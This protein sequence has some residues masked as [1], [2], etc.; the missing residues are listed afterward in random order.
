MTARAAIFALVVCASAAA[1]AD[2]T[3]EADEA[4]ETAQAA[5]TADTDDLVESTGDSTGG[6][7]GVAWMHYELSAVHGV[8]APADA[9]APQTLALGGARV[10]GVLGKGRVGYHLG[11]DFAFGS[12]VGRAGFA[13][14][15]ALFPLGIGLRLGRTGVL[16][17]GVGGQASGA[18]GAIDDALAVPVEALLEAGG[19]LRLLVRARAAWLVGADGRQRGAPSA[20]F[21]DEI[22]GM[23]AL[24]VGHAYKDFGL[25]SGNGYFVGAAFRE[26][27]GTRF[28][29]LVIGYSVDLATPRPQ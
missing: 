29:G 8:Q 19:G 6:V 28:A 27:A 12:T 23:L 2:D 15:V 1:R 18:V 10:H 16:A 21:A 22:E 25:P 9:M 4:D 13:Y 14:D 26:L 3:D 24:R 7:R 17:L 11:F 5:E 20:T